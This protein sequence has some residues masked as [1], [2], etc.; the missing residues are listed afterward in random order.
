MKTTK[1]DKAKADRRKAAV[2]A[3]KARP[4]AGEKSVANLRGRMAL[5]EEILGLEE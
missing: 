5:F 4:M 3:I 2:D 1:I